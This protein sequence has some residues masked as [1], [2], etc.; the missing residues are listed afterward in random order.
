MHY[1][2]ALL[3][4]LSVGRCRCN[5]KGVVYAIVLDLFLGVLW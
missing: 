4:P 2:A 5:G 3:C 1:R